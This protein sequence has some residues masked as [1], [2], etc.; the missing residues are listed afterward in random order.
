MNYN[1]LI[2]YSFHL[3]INRACRQTRFNS[4]HIECLQQQCKH[5]ILFWFQYII[6]SDIVIIPEVENSKRRRWPVALMLGLLLVSAVAL[7]A[8]F[9]LKTN[10]TGMYSMNTDTILLCNLYFAMIF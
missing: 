3:I 4:L 7:A 2:N 5:D 10:E 9:L 1:T 6:K 8:A